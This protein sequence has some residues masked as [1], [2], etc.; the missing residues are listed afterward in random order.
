MKILINIGIF[1]AN[2]IYFFIKLFPTHTNKITFISRQSNDVALDFILLKKELLKKDKKLEIKELCKKIEPGL[3]NKLTYILHILVQ[4]YHIATSKVVIL[5]TYCIP[6]CILKHKKNLTIIQMWHALGSLK[7]FGYSSLDTA[8]GRSSE[9]SH[10]MRMHKNYDYIL[11]SSEASLPNFQEAFNAQKE[12]MVVMNLPRVDYLKSKKIE[13]D[14]KK[15][16]YKKYPKVDKK[17]KVILYCPTSRKNSE[18]PLEEI[19]NSVNLDQYTLILKLHNNT[20][21]IYYAKDKYYE[22]IYFTGMDMLHV[23]DYIITDYSAISYEA[24]ITK[25]PIYLYIYDYEKYIDERGLYIDY[26]KEM[27]GFISKDIKKIIE[28]IEKNKY[29]PERTEL[30]LKKYIANLSINWTEKFAEFVIDKTTKEKE[31]K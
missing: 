4:M 17:K 27:P 24:A 9:I 30:F 29:E 25:K 11:T 1:F 28:N 21:K 3:K 26:K 2:L 14:I 12:N 19:V 8:D 6:I 16:F 18:L 20:N 31:S 22:K 10:L 23:A 15:E 13:K 5:D 7:K